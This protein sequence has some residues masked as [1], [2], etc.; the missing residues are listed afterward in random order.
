M[1][2]IHLKNLR[3]LLAHAGKDLSWCFNKEGL[4]LLRVNQFGQNVSIFPPVDEKENNERDFWW[5]DAT[6]VIGRVTCLERRV[7]I[8]NTLTRKIIMMNV[9]EEDNIKVI[10]AKYRKGFNDNADSYIWRKTHSQDHRGRLFMDKTLTQNGILF[11][12][13]EQLGLPPAI[14]L[15][16]SSNI[17]C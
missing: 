13:N 4:P 17:F 6:Y 11:H 1:H 3:L 8:V 2:F 14:W 12:E 7:R 10:K 9:C 15:Y 16:Y 5:R